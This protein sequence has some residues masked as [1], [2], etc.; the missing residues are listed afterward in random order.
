MYIVEMLGLA[1]LFRLTVQESG[2]EERKGWLVGK[3]GCDLEL[4]LCGAA[5]VKW[6]KAESNHRFRF[7]DGCATQKKSQN[8]GE[9]RNKGL[10]KYMSNLPME[11][12]LRLHM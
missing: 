2:V 4:S 6:L 11:L 1:R 10:D 9:D 12:G 3:R 5:R 7:D 8:A